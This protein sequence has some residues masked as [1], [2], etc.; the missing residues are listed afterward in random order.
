M[1]FRDA[2]RKSNPKLAD[3]IEGHVAEISR[4]LDGVQPFFSEY[5]DHSVRHSERVLELA[6]RLGVGVANDFER[7]LLILF[8]YYH[9]WGMVVSPQEYGE[10]VDS[11]GDDT[12]VRLYIENACSREDVDDVDP[13]TGRKLLALEHFR[14]EHATRSARKIRERFPTVQA[15]SFFDHG[16]YFWETLAALCDA[17][18]RDIAQI[19]GD[20]SISCSTAL[21]GGVTVDAVFLVAV[22]RL[23]DACHFGRDR[24]LPFLKKGRQ[25]LSSRSDG[26]WKY[27]ADVADTIPNPNTHRIEV[28]AKCDDF[29]IHRAI[30]NNAHEIQAELVN[31]Q[32]LL[33]ERHSDRTF[34]WKYVDTS[35][36]V[37]AKND[38]DY[39]D[40]RFTLDRRHI[41]EL[42]MGDRLYRSRLYSLRECIQNAVDAVTAY[43]GKA[44]ADYSPYVVVDLGQD[45]IVDI[46]D[47]GTGMDKDIIDKH[48][49]AVG[50]SAFWYSDRGIRD[51]GGVR[52]NASLIAEH[53]I[54]TLSYFMLAKQAEVFSIYGPSGKP[55]HVMLD[56]YLDGVVFKNTPISEFPSFDAPEVGVSPPWALGHGTLIRMH[57]GQNVDPGEVL[58]FL[59]KHILRI[60]SAII[61]RAPGKTLQ[62]PEV[63]HLR[64]GID[65]SF[66]GFLRGRVLS[67]AAGRTRLDVTEV[68][69]DL[70]TP[71]QGYYEGPP[72]DRAIT[73][74]AYS[75]GKTRY[76]VR[77]NAGPGSREP[78]RLSQHGIAVED[79]GDF[80]RAV[81]GSLPLFDTFTVDVDVRDRCLQLS[82][83]RAEISSTAHNRLI[84]QELM[85]AFVESYFEQVSKI[86]SPIYFPCG[87]RY[88]H[89]MEY[90]LFSN[91]LLQ[92]CFHR[93]LKEFFQ[94]QEANRH[95][96]VDRELAFA[97]A[98]LYCVGTDRSRPTSVREIEEDASVKEVLV[99][100]RVFAE[101]KPSISE[102]SGK[103]DAHLDI[104]ME[105]VRRRATAPDKL[106]YIPGDRGAFVLPIALRIGLSV[107]YE[108]DE[109][110]ILTIRRGRGSSLDASL[111]L[112][113]GE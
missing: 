18:C 105:D 11:L 46:Y 108:N 96:V 8:S 98:H 43:A 99:L 32:R 78:F 83:S 69:A 58:R 54:G 1:Q 20:P 33:T 21:G 27:Y 24:A 60:S 81:R 25:F 101:S 29:Y 34:D 13:D 6:E 22:S 79:A 80:F 63:W 106:V 112:L 14:E 4:M 72:R 75:I 93:S 74:N 38:Y 109:F 45:G 35:A 65:D 104:F 5:T 94:D 77:L 102:T 103:R 37:P 86:E 40:S 17:H 7:A 57:L 28:F 73:E 50:A 2:L 100:R 44:A 95:W 70:Y 55:M 68:F 52:R 30:V 19:L 85:E 56:D 31:A 42:L 82:A 71:K 53:G 84:A 49:L 64:S 97:N 107:A 92:V 26:I 67:P 111:R 39:H 12:A 51:W 9:D 3:Y 10:Y 61:L 15:S 90:V 48:F 89:G 47:N 36:V 113:T 88:Y 110:R 87:G 91:N 23:A 66:Y 62:L 41:T 16:V 76:R 59:G